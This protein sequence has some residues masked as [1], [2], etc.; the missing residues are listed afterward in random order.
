MSVSWIISS[1]AIAVA[2]VP[3]KNQHPVPVLLGY[4]IVRDA[5]G[6]QLEKT[7]V[8]APGFSHPPV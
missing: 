8:V 2:G 5:R 6:P 3:P 7:G 4:W 1:Q